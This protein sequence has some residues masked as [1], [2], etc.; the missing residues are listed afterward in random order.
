MIRTFDFL[1]DVERNHE[2]KNQIKKCIAD[3][4][5]AEL[6]TT[7]HK[8]RFDGAKQ[9]LVVEPLSQDSPFRAKIIPKAIPYDVL[10][11]MLDGAWEE[12]SNPRI[13]TL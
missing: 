1:L 5:T 13:E 12:M 7:I 6:Y 3:G 9:M 10:E 11:K 4:K 8:L 2:L